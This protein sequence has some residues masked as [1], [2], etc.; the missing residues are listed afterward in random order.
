[1]I[2]ASAPHAAVFAPAG[3]ALGAEFVRPF[4]GWLVRDEAAA[5]EIGTMS[6]I[7]GAGQSAL[8][9]VRPDAFE[10]MPPALYVYR[11]TTS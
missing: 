8:R 10:P 11:Q 9:T 2:Q 7:S 6:E 4:A 5:Q 3:A 1:V